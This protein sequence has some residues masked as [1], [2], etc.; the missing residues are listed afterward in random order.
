MTR[1]PRGAAFFDLDR[2]LMAGSSAFQ[3]GRASYAAGLINRREIAKG[4]WAN[5]RFRLRGSMRHRSPNQCRQS[6]PVR[7]C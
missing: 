2:T 5:V 3:F 4:A 7:R 6:R 1:A